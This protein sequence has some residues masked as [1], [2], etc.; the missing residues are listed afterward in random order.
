[1]AKEDFLTSERWM[2]GQSIEK[3][4]LPS[5]NVLKYIFTD[6]SWVCLRPSGTEPKFKIYYSVNASSQPSATQKMQQLRT[7]FH[8]LL[9]SE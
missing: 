7:A 6:G 4:T 8:Q 1:M 9:K 3:I 2:A 5:S